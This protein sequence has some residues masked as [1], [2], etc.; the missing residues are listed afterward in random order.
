MLVSTLALTVKTLVASY[1]RP[2]SPTGE[3]AAT[4]LGR[5]WAKGVVHLPGGDDPERLA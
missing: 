5:V 2:G 1:E 4:G 3:L